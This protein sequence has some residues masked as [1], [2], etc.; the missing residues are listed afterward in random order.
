[1]KAKSLIIIVIFSIIAFAVFGILSSRNL[2]RIAFG[3]GPGM[4]DFTKNI[5]NGY[6]LY[7]NSKEDIFVA[8]NDGWNDEIEII[9]SK[10]LKLNEYKDYIVA[11]RQGLK[12]QNPNDEQD[13]YKI[14]DE[15]VIDYWI[16]DTENNIALKNLNKHEFKTKL[17]SLKIPRNI[18]LIDVYEY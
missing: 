5:T 8:P 16:L 2:P 13:K 7:R 3:Y 15:K 4:Q 1:M 12:R 10:V 18:G 17:E 14:S 6:V 11:E 9:P